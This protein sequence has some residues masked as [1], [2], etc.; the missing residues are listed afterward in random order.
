MGYALVVIRWHS[1]A[2]D[3]F[4]KPPSPFFPAKPSRLKTDPTGA[5]KNLDILWLSQ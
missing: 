2:F 3:R 4:F 1:I 5:E